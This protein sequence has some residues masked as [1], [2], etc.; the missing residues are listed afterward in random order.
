MDDGYELKIKVLISCIFEGSLGIQASCLATLVPLYRKIREVPLFRR[1][2]D[3]CRSYLRMLPWSKT[4]RTGTLDPAPSPLIDNPG[5]LTSTPTPNAF[6][7]Q[8]AYYQ[9]LEERNRAA[10][11]PPQFP[12]IPTSPDR[13]ASLSFPGSPTSFSPILDPEPPHPPTSPRSTSSEY[14]ALPTIHSGQ[15][16]QM[17]D[18]VSTMMS[19]P[20]TDSDVTDSYSLEIPGTLT[21]APSRANLSS[22]TTLTVRPV[23]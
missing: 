11:P 17:S 19:I 10:S 5:P 1:I 14:P 3:R 6:M 20:R 13:T 22:P 2:R 8:Q 12:G 16:L 21:E 4:D 7:R 9:E 15:V 23:D 18:T